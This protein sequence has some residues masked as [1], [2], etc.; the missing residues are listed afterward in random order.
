M[1]KQII[2]R[3]F[4]VPLYSRSLYSV[5]GVHQV[6][7]IFL[8]ATSEYLNHSSSGVPTLTEIKQEFHVK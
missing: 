1:S 7:S 5:L 6:T 3:Y 8:H 2:S 4:W